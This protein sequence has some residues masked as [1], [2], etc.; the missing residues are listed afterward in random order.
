MIMRISGSA[1]HLPVPTKLMAAY[2]QSHDY[3]EAQHDLKE[4]IQALIQISYHNAD[5]IRIL[6]CTSRAKAI[7]GELRQVCLGFGINA[8]SGTPTVAGKAPHYTSRPATSHI[9]QV[10]A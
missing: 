6:A 7:D 8:I 5:V 9:D 10:T 4:S 2:T 1:G 3:S